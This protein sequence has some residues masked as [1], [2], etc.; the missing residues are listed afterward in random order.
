MWE[1]FT[2]PGKGPHDHTHTRETEIFRVIRGTY[3]FR[4]GDDV[5][6]SRVKC[7]SP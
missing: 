7:S 4:C 1:T 6:T 2:P 3:R 5:A